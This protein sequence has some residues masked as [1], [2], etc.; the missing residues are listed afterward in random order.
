VLFW[1]LEQIKFLKYLQLSEI[2]LIFAASECKFWLSG[3][4]V[5]P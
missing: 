3:K 5:R 4:H 2:I 1:V